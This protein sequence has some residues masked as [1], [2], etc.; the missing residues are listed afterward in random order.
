M[1]FLK[2]TRRPWAWALLA[3]LAALCVCAAASA[4]IALRF[5]V[6]ALT[7]TADEVVVGRVLGSNAR[8]EGSRIMTEVQVQVATP[9]L[10]Q[11]QPGQTLTLQTPGGRVGDLAQVIQGTPS[12]QEGQEVL[13]FLERNRRSGALRTVGLAQGKF[14]LY[15]DPQDQLWVRQQLE[16]LTLAEPAQKD[17][18][19]R[20]VARLAQD[21]HQGIEPMALEEMVRQVAQTARRLE[22]RVRPELQQAL[23]DDL[24]GRYDFKKA[25]QALDPPT[26]GA[27]Q[28]Q[29]PQPQAPK[30][31][32]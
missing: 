3:S 28:P 13:L 18:R 5:D 29:V 31:T 23:G 12:F 22:L 26:P 24:R 2:Q 16:G 21:A 25:L 11:S 27:L 4:T 6:E 8:W 7:S 15:R 10:G 30:T 32:F 14:T 17:D 9:I 20:T 1:K 19:G